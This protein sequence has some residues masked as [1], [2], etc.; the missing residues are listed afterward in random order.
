MVERVTK[1]IARAKHEI[2]KP[3]VRIDTRSY[4]HG[5]DEQPEHPFELRAHA[6]VDR[7]A[8]DDVGLTRVT[9]ENRGERSELHRV[10]GGAEL[11][12][13][14]TKRSGKARRYRA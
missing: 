14:A 12:R 3:D 4:R 6:P 13:R 9:T 8:D 11:P 2:T 1:S 5:V 10:R 7:S